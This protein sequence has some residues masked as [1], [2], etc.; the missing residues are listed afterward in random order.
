MVSQKVYKKT[1]PITAS[2]IGRCLFRI[3][4]RKVDTMDEDG[5]S[6]ISMEPSINSNDIIV[7]ARSD[8]I[9]AIHK[10]DGRRLWRIKSP[11]GSSG[12]IISIYVTEDYKV[13]LGARGKA[14]CIELRTGKHLWTQKMK[15]RWICNEVSILSTPYHF[16]LSSMDPKTMSQIRLLAEEEIQNQEYNTSYINQD[17]DDDAGYHSKASS[18]SK[19]QPPTHDENNDDGGETDTFNHR[20]RSTS[21]TSETSDKEDEDNK[22]KKDP[23]RVVCAT[24]W[25]R[26]YGF[27][28]D[29]GDQL[30]CFNCP[31]GRIG[32]PTILFDKQY[33]DGG[34]HLFVACNTMI[35]C[36]DSKTGKLQ[37]SEK[38]S[39]S[40]WSISAYVTL[41]TGWSSRLAAE[42]Y[43]GGFS[44][45]PIVQIADVEEKIQVTARLA[46][47]ILGGGVKAGI[48]VAGA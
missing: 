36:L 45:Q 28:M 35:Y 23:K 19:L 2:S 33:N 21:A 15:R 37:W 5:A 7:C 22:A 13:L 38:I 4:K 24:S 44:Q 41:A 11:I 32:F 14:A 43:S 30:W 17:Q 42:A 48:A 27:D 34:W 25:G 6:A 20:R 10:E 39:N 3:K 31:K 29:N 16:S 46:I 18:S 12:G 40:R 47:A 9:Y 8:K 1:R 26:C